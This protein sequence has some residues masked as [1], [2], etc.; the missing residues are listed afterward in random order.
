MLT[1]ICCQSNEHLHDKKVHQMPPPILQALEHTLKAFGIDCIS[2]LQ[3]FWNKKVKEV[4]TK[5]EQESMDLL[6][7]YNVQKV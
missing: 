3:V 7:E 2:S 4:A 1:I 5:L 6:N